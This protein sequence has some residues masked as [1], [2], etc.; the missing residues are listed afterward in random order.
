MQGEIGRKSVHQ[1]FMRTSYIACLESKDA[2][3]QVT[4]FWEKMLQVLRG[5]RC[6]FR[7]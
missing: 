6:S 7:D 1:R 4:T 2:A 5:E 3:S